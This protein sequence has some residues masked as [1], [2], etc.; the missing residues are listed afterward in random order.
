MDDLIKLR[1]ECRA[2]AI[3]HLR[4]CA[5]ELLSWH[6]TGTLCDGRLRELAR[7]MRAVYG[8]DAL[9]HAERVVEREALRVAAGRPA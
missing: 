4:E 8:V 7:M 3:Q 5:D 6:G 9:G 2:F 1:G